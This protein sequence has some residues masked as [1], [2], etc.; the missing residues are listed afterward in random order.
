[1]PKI[2]TAHKHINTASRDVIIKKGEKK[3]CS[4]YQ[5]HICIYT[6][7]KLA[8]FWEFLFIFSYNL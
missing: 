2:I 5:I 4:L 8:E 6:C 1:M 3:A 7:M